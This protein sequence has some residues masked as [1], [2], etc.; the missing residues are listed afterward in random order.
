M[1]EIDAEREQREQ[2]AEDGGRQPGQDRERMDVAL[3]QDAEDE[4]DDEHRQ[5]RAA[6]PC[7]SSESWKACALPW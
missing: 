4:I 6:Y 7:P 1:F 3:V 2:R 5:R